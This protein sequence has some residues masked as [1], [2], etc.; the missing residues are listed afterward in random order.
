MKLYAAAATVALLL[1]IIQTT[2]SAAAEEQEVSCGFVMISP[3]VLEQL[4]NAFWDIIQR[5][6]DEGITLT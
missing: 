6:M 2:P 5:L 3:N 1:A 4:F